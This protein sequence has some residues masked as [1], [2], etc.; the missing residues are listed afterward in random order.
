MFENL[1]E[2][3]PGRLNWIPSLYEPDHNYNNRN[4]QK[5]MNEPPGSISKKS[6]RPSNDQD[7]CN[8]IKY[9]SHDIR[10]LNMMN[11]MKTRKSFSPSKYL[12]IT[13]FYDRAN[14]FE[15]L[16]GIKAMGCMRWYN[17]PLT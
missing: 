2:K 5:E 7:H 11:E 12:F 4:H 16:I 15:L 13:A 3:T 17:Y 8:D 9:I 1:Y 6:N 14:H 10:F